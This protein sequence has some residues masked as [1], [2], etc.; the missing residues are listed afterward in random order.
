MKT[1][2]VDQAVRGTPAVLGTAASV[3]TLNT[4][5]MI[6]TAVYIVLQIAYLIRKW[7]REE[8]TYKVDNAV[9]GPSGARQAG[10]IDTAQKA[11]TP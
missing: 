6:G 1:E 10:S 7:W 8:R 3:V 4:W 5:V 11:A 9:S 2:V